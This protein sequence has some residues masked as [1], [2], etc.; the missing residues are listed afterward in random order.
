MLRADPLFIEK[1]DATARGVASGGGRDP[2]RDDDVSLRAPARSALAAASAGGAEAAV[3]RAGWL[4]R[5][6]LA[7]PTQGP[8]FA[9]ALMHGVS[10]FAAAH[11]GARNPELGAFAMGAN[12]VDD[13]VSDSTKQRP[14]GGGYLGAVARLPPAKG[15]AEIVLARV[16]ELASRIAQRDARTALLALRSRSPDT[17]A[18]A[19]LLARTHA[20]LARYAFALPVRRFVHG[21]F[22]RVTGSD[23]SWAVVDAVTRD[24]RK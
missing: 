24:D 17:F 13:S 2:E 9:H 4:V 22:D 7:Q 6:S 8:L 14:V 20:I 19:A 12:A 18:S 11:G 1:L 10:P 3:L 23:R 5:G 21:L 16:A 15:D